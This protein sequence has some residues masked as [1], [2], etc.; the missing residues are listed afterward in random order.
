MQILKVTVGH[1]QQ[2]QQQNNVNINNKNKIDKDK[3]PQWQRHTAA[4]P[5]GL[6]EDQ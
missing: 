6:L 1:Q 5:P 4:L 2:Q 3:A